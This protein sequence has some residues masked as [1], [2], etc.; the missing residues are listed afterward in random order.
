MDRII[1]IQMIESF[2]NNLVEEEKSK[3]TVEK[4][5][6]DIRYFYRFAGGR[7]IDRAIVLEY[8]SELRKSYAVASANSMLAALNAFFHYV[9]YLDCCVK[10]FKIQRKVCSP[11]E[12]ELTRDEYLRLVKAA[13]D[14]G[15]ERLS[16]ILQTICSTGIRVS[17]LKYITVESVT[18]GTVNVSC[19]GKNRMIFIVKQLKQLLLKYAKKRGIAEGEIFL[20]KNGNS[21]SR[22]SIW[23]EMK[24]ICAKAKVSEKK[25]FPHNLRHLFA[26]TFYKME[27]DIAKL[28][29]ILGHSNVNTTMIYIISTGAEHRRMMERMRMIV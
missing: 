21:I 28:A 2:K 8:K 5:V 27:K 29:D 20:T 19:K 1:N 4:Y 18:K 11:E 13:V 6:R 22:S 3:C 17:E 7:V 12:L 14:N 25:V 23:R 16:L 9:G 15:N 10:L 26:R 24:A